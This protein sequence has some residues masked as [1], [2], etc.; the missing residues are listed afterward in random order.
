MRSFVPPLLAALALAACQEQ[1]TVA[2]QFNAI[3]ADVENKA[4]SYDAE[5]ENQVREAEQR[6]SNEAEALFRQNEN[7]LGEAPEV[8]VDVN[9]E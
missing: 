4:R 6:A 3:A 8:E 1:P 2:E 9:A 5:A 7:A